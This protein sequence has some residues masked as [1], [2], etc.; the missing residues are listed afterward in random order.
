MTP[1]VNA[2]CDTNPND[3]TEGEGNQGRG[4]WD[5]EREEEGSGQMLLIKFKLLCLGFPDECCDILKF[6]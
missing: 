5:D 3:A 4:E 6:D 2:L 1:K